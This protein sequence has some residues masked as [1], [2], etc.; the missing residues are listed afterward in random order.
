MIGFRFEGKMVRF[1]LTMPDRNDDRFRFTAARRKVRSPEQ[2]IVE[3][4]KGCRQVWRALALVVKAK[5]EAVEAGI[6]TFEEEFLAQLV[7]PGGQTVAE[8][9]LPAIRKAFETGRMPAALLPGLGE[10][11]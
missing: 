3:W 7:L 1:L 4:E 10:T 11:S 9:A 6:V 8:Q 2:S 5:L